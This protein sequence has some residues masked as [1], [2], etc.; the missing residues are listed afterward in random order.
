VAELRQAQERDSKRVDLQVLL[1][2]ALWRDE[3]R[4]DAV[5]V[6]LQLLDVLPDSIKAN[7]ILAE[8]WLLTGRLQEAQDYLN[9][10]QEMLL[11][12][13]SSLDPNDPAGIAFRLPGA[14]PLPDVF[15]VTMMDDEAIFAADIA[16]TAGWVAE[17]G[18][19]V[20]ETGAPDDAE[21]GEQVPDWL[22]AMEQS[23]EVLAAVMKEEELAD[24]F[25]RL[26]LPKHS[27]PPRSAL[28]SQRTNTRS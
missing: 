27:A 24:W 18:L 6:C 4:V 7:A 2:E 3:Q 8:V 11:P 13:M 22:L 26:K 23:D 19:G 20:A 15:M 21:L 5:D 28:L 16:D 14:K 1:A 9:K 25:A 12:D 10:V 17:L